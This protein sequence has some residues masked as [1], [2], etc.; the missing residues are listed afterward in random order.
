MRCQWCAAPFAVKNPNNGAR[1]GTRTHD[2]LIHTRHRF[3][4]PAA[5]A[6]GLGSGLSLR[7]IAGHVISR[8]KFDG[9]GIGAT[10]AGGVKSLHSPRRGGGSTGLPF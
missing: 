8:V 6:S 1:R 10:Q 7:H 2:L 4:G 5:G 9:F 3:H